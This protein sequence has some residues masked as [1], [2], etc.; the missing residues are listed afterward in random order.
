LVIYFFD[1]LNNFSN[2]F[3][4]NKDVFFLTFIEFFGKYVVLLPVGV[5]VGDFIWYKTITE[6]GL[7]F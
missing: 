3:I 1:G 5:I 4:N 7:L 2:Y 6:E